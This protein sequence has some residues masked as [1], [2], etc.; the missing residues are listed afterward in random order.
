MILL[1]GV[2]FLYFKEEI[3][4]EYQE[5]LISILKF[6]KFSNKKSNNIINVKINNV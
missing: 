4:N 1:D 2:G 6:Q 3:R 5:G